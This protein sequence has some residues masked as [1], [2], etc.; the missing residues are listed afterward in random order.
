MPDETRTFDSDTELALNRKSPCLT[1]WTQAKNR[2]NKPALAK[3]KY[4]RTREIILR[5]YSDA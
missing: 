4:R 3:G 2:Q 1:G 5:F